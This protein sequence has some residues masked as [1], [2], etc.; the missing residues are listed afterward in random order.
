VYRQSLGD[1]P[2]D[3]AQEAQELAV[4]VAGQALPDHLAGQHVQRREQGGGAVALV[5]DLR[6]TK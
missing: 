2:V 4:A 5:V 3:G 1:L 6:L